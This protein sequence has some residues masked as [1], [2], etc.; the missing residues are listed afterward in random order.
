MIG[1]S[2]TC[3]KPA[4][5]TYF[6]RRGAISRYEGNRPGSAGSRIHEPRCTSYTDIGADNVWR[7]AR[8]RIHSASFQSYSSVHRIEA[9]FGGISWKVPNGSALSTRYPLYRDSIWNL[10]RAPAAASGTKPS[11][12]PELERGASRCA[13]GS[14]A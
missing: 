7:S 5:F 2:S 10:Y 9:V 3:V 8:A 14:H 11:Q 4:S 13:P 6:A 12:I 1:S